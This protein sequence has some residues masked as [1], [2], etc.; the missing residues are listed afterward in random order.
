[1]RPNPARA[2]AVAATAALLAVLTLPH[3]A[4]AAPGAEAPALPSEQALY[5]AK[6]SLDRAAPPATAVTSWYVDPAEDALVVTARPGGEPAVAQ[7]LAATGV[8]EE[9]VQVVPAEG[10]PRLF[11]PWPLREGDPYYAGQ[12]RC[13]VGFLVTTPYGDNGFITAG[14]CGGVGTH[15]WGFN[16][17]PQGVFQISVFPSKDWAL[18]IVNDNW[19]LDPQATGS[20]EAPIGGSVCKIGSTTG[21]TCGTI[22]A[23]NV[24][25]NYPQ[26]TVSGLTQTTICAEPGDSGGPVFSGTEGQGIVSGGS[27]NCSVGGTTYFQPL[28]PILVEGN[29]TLVT[30]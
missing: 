26:G 27:G 3:P 18:V 17:E 5:A 22:T 7:F 29:L 10:T 20:Q 6:E 24:T 13:T 30:A 23:K 25:V 21:M 19:I 8:A 16:Q 2:L 4:S 11:Q 9:L 12:F 1:M 15:T 28:N 14:H